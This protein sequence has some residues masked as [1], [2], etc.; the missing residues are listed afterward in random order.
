MKSDYDYEVKIFLQGSYANNT[1]VRQHSDVDIAVVQIDQFRPKYRVGVSKTN[2]G[3]ISA[4]SKSKTF[5]D[6]VQSALENKFGN[7]VERKT[8]FTQTNNWKTYEDMNVKFLKK[9]QKPPL[10]K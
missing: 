4:I 10:Q 5:K 3:F 1:N 7:D 2:Y 8:I 9:L 6:I